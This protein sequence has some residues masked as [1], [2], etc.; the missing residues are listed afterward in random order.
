MSKS[1]FANFPEKLDEVKSGRGK[2]GKWILAMECMSNTSK[3][4]VSTS[5]RELCKQDK[6]YMRINHG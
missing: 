6:K 1:Q 5:N 3:I 2:K 4:V